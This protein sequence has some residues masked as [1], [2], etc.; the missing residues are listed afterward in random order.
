MCVKE[1]RAGLEQ[2]WQSFAQQVAGPAFLPLSVHTAPPL[3][4]TF[5]P[6]LSSVSSP[7]KSKLHS[8]PLY[9]E[10][11]LAYDLHHVLLWIVMLI[12]IS[13]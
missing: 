3:V 10:K 2:Y 9:P 12:R 11:R 8:A 4:K 1:N 7:S 6:A 5:T 13:Y